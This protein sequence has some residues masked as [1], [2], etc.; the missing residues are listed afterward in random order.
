MIEKQKRHYVSYSWTGCGEG[1]GAS[2][3]LIENGIFNVAEIMDSIIKENGFET[4]IIINF[5]EMKGH[6][7]FK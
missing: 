6:E 1:Y 7:V 3:V 4:A 2:D 5:F